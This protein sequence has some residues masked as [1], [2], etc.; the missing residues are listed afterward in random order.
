MEA[1]APVE[2]KRA[3]TGGREAKPKARKKVLSKEEKSVK[4]A[5]R[6]GWR[7]NL[8]EKTA[9]AANQQVWQMQMKAG[10]AQ[11]ALHSSLAEGYMLVKR[12]GIAGVAPPASSV[13]S[14]SS[15]LRPE[16][17]APLQGHP[18]SRFDDITTTPG[19][20]S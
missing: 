1:A 12:E 20:G 8:K 11:V 16:T 5:K 3:A 4:A 7:K 14:V 6:H 17:P 13:S 2:A 18:V 19:P 10:V 15:Q 9:P